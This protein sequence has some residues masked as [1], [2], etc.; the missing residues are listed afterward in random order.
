MLAHGHVR[1]VPRR[2]RAA[3]H[4]IMF[5]RGNHAVIVR[6]L[7]LHPFHK[8][9]AHARRQDGSS[10]YVSCPRPQRGSRNILMFGGPEIQP[11]KNIAVA[12]AFE[13]HVLDAASVPI[14]TAIW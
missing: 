8:R 14:T 3:V 9:H 1:F 10:P 6:I 13:L 2:L 7:S 11:F 12:R 5:R 4:R